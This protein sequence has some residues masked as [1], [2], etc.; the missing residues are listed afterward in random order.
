[1]DRNLVEVG[2]LDDLLCLDAFACE[3]NERNLYC[4]SHALCKC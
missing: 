4:V 2:Q 3:W 1:M